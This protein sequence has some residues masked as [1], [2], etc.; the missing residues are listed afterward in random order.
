[1]ASE[2]TQKS[3]ERNRPPRVH[4]LT[5]VELNGAL[6]K[7][8]VP[9]LTGVMA[10]LSGDKK[11]PK[12]LK[13][14]QFTSIDKDNFDEVLAGIEPELRLEVN[15]ALE[16]D[17]SD[18]KLALKFRS[19]EDFSPTAVARQIPVLARLLETRSKLVDLKSRADG[20]DVLEDLLEAILK[21]E[22]FRGKVESAIKDVPHGGDK[23]E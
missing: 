10:D 15:N 5:E 7:K 13:D 18:L 16:K 21:N 17:Q 6:V 2:S 4:L 20:R 22:T 8:E 12:K 11:R 19:L 14:R 3:L 9:F 23:A 1:M